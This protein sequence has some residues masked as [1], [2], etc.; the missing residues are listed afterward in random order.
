[1]SSLQPVSFAISRPSLEKEASRRKQYQKPQLEELGDLRTLTMG[2]SPGVMDSGSKE[3][4]KPPG[5]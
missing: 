3:T 1:M 2:G 4:R 5:T